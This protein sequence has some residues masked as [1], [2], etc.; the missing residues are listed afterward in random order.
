M[1]ATPLTM[2]EHLHLKPSSF[3][4][5]GC[6]VAHVLSMFIPGLFTGNII[7]AIG[8]FPVMGVGIIFQAACALITL[9]GYQ[10]ANFYVGL[11]LLGAGWNFAFVAS[12]MLL[13]SSHAPEER[14][15]VTSFN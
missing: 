9:W 6:I 1:S 2:V 15:K 10:T 4:V 5:S 14:T 3:L 12:T 11:I 8:K 7:G 13:L